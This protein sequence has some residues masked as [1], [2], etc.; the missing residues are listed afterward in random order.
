MVFSLPFSCNLW[1]E[2]SQLSEYQRHISVSPSF[3]LPFFHISLNFSHHSFPVFTPAFI[4][5]FLSDGDGASS[6]PRDVPPLKSSF[7]DLPSEQLHTLISSF[8][9]PSAFLC[10][11]TFDC[12]FL[13]VTISPWPS[14]AALH[15]A[16]WSAPCLLCSSKPVAESSRLQRSLSESKVNGWLFEHTLEVGGG[17]EG[18]GCGGWGV[19]KR[20]SV[21]FQALHRTMLTTLMPFFF[22]LLLF[23]LLNV[24]NLLIC[25]FI[26]SCVQGKLLLGWSHYWNIFFFY[27]QT[28]SDAL[29]SRCWAWYM[30]R[31]I[32]N[33]SVCISGGPQVDNP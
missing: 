11:F 13:V 3:S 12:I 25:E 8:S 30:I 26:C 33:V 9:S 1:T 19:I 6:P 28:I 2:Q 22:T 14:C 31:E 7:S 10:S 4:W 29:H 5:S 27:P 16:G 23:P 17:R 15:L 18:W 24:H 20:H 32:E 21:V